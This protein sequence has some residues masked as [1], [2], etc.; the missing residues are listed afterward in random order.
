MPEM[1]PTVSRGARLMPRTCMDISAP[2]MNTT[3]DPMPAGLHPA[4]VSYFE[5]QETNLQTGNEPPPLPPCKKQDSSAGQRVGLAKDPLPERGRMTCSK[6][7]CCRVPALASLMRDC[8]IL[9]T[10]CSFMRR[11]THALQRQAHT[12][13]IRQAATHH[14]PRLAR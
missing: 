9:E 8:S 5:L 2:H 3:Q 12:T 11:T 13:T 6:A 1:P 4:Q 14:A 7:A 10:S